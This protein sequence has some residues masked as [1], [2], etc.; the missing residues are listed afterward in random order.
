MT[1]EPTVVHL[2]LSIFM[3]YTINWLG[4]HSIS[5]GYITLTAF[6]KSDDAPAFNLFFRVLSPIVLIILFASLFYSFGYDH[7]VQNIWVV[8][9]FYCVGRFLFILIFE[10]VHL[11]NWMREAFIWVSSTGVSWIVYEYFIQFKTNLL[12]QPE[13]LK[14]EF[15]VL[16]ILFIYSVFNHIE[17]NGNATIKRKQNYCKKAYKH[18]K[19]RFHSII[20][21]ESV[22]T[23]SESL[24]YAILLYENFNRPKLIRMVERIT[25]PHIAKSLGPMQVKTETSLSDF[26]SV[27]QGSARVVESY[28]KALKIG[29]EKA[30]LREAN[31]N[32]FMD[33]SHMR[34]LGYKVASD[35][36][37]DD[38]YVDGVT[39]MHEQLIENIYSTFKPL[40]TPYD[41]SDMYFY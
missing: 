24:I 40:E 15:W 39:E 8:T 6:V 30:A 12:P 23:L 27:R 38:S 25:F 9:L 37:K 3:F 19:E 33:S 32:P 1:L 26:D 35:Y 41:R 10:R 36:N 5:L 16:L 29:Q 7:Y 31:F 17:F 4:K 34:F 18:H 11:I 2:I 21:V 20:K 14:N 28:L 13:E 22:D